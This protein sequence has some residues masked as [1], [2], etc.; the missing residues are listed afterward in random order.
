M[1]RLLTLACV[2][3]FPFAAVAQNACEPFELTSLDGR[4][5]KT[6]DE[7]DEGPSIDDRRVGERIIGDVDKNPV[8]EVRWQITLLDPDPGPDG[9]THNLLRMFFF[10]DD[11]TI[12]AE[13]VHSPAKHLHD[14]DQVSAAR[15]EL[16]VLGGTGAF[17]HAKG[18]IEMHPGSD[19]NPGDVVYDVDISCD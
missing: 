7:G 10:F 4:I 8:G 11:G 13:G 14:T 16:I 6:V 12:L 19:G 18:M 15:T 9:P 3:A 2:A 1:N 17:R 5:V